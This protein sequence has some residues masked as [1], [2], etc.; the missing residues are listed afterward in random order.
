MN[1]FSYQRVQTADE[2]LVAVSAAGATFLGGGTNLVDLM[3]GGVEKPAKLVD[4]THLNLTSIRRSSDGAVMIEA[5]V[6]NSAVANHEII[7]THYPMLSQ[8]I[9]S[10]A[11]TQLRNMATTGG[12]LL[13]KTRCS[14]FMDPSFDACNKRKPGSGCAAVEGFNRGHAILG[15][16][17][18]CVAINPSDMGV[19]LAA[20]GAMVHI[21]SSVGK[22]RSVTL[23]DF[24]RLPGAT[25]H[26]ET[27]LAAGELI[28]G[29]ELPMSKFSENSWYLK[30]R[31]RHSYAFALVSVAAGLEMSGGVIQ[32]A[33]LAL[34]GVAPKPWRLFDVEAF[35]A[36]TEPRTDIF[37]QAAEMALRGARPLK[38]NTFKVDLAKHSIVR[39]LTLAARLTQER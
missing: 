11:S 38:C 23:E 31:D 6:R 32:S 18:S 13:Q 21:R 3:K 4:V 20:L 34:G 14:Y 26:I 35:L 8:A 39:A 19:A 29:V 2:A 25:P 10:G 5:G 9:L 7:R 37:R 36:G 17:E 22:N 15:A 27:Q 12:N 24:Y 1:P 33:G 30:V 16:S 28:T